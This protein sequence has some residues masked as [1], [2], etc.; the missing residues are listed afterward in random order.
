M[1]FPPLKDK[2]P[3]SYYA[4]KKTFKMIRLGNQSIHAC[5]NDCFLFR[6]EDHKD[7]QIFPVCNTSRWKDSNTPG[8]K[9]PKK[10]LRYF[11]II[12]RL[13]RLYKSSHTTKEMTWHATRK[14]TEPGK[15]QH[16]VDDRAWKN[17]DTK[18]FMLTLLI[19]GPKSPGKDIDVYLRPLIDD[20]KDLWAKP[21]VETID[22]IY[23][24]GFF[25]IM[26]HLV[27]H[28]PLEALKGKPVRPRWM[29]PFERFM[30][31]L[32][33]YVRNKAKL[34]G[35]I[36]EGYVTEE[37]L[38]F[39]SF[40]FHDVTTKCNR[41][42]RNV[43]C[44]PLTCQF[45]VFRS[46]CKS[47]GLRSVIR[48]DHQE[49][50]KVIW[51]V[52]HNSPEIDTYRVKFK[53]QFSN[54]DMK[55]EFPSWFGSQVNLDLLYKDP[56]VSTSSELFALACGPTPTPIS[57]NSCVVNGV[58][59]VVHSRD[60]RR[61]TQNSGICSLG[62]DGEMYYGQ[63]EEIL[64]FSYMSFKTVLF[65][66]FKNDQYILAT[67]VKQCFYLED[68]ARR[69]LDW[70][71]AKHVNHKKFSNGG[72]IVVE[73]DPDIIHVDNSSDLA[74]T[75]SLNDLEIAALHIDGQ[76]IDV[77]APL[78][79]I[80]VDENDDIID[81]EDVLPYD[82]ADSND[83]DLVNVY[84]DD[85]GVAMSDVAR[86]HGDDGG[87]DD[88]PLHISMGTRKPNL[89][90]RKAGMI[91]TRKETRN[92]GLRKI[93]NE[94]GPQSIRFEWKDNGTMLPLGDH[95]SHWA[96]LL[97]EI[98]REFPMHF[99]SWRSILAER[100]AGVLEKIR[101]GHR[102]TSW[103]D[104]HGQQVDVEEGLLRLRTPMTRLTTWKLSDPDVP[105][106]SLW[107]IG[108]S[109]SGFGLI[110]RTWPSV[111]K[112]LETRQRALSYVGRD[113]GYLLPSEIELRDSRVLVPNP[114]LL[115]YTY[116]WWRI[117][118][119][120]GSMSISQKS[121]K[122]LQKQIDMITKAMSSDDR[123]S[124]LFTQL[125]SQHESGSGATKDDESGDDKDAD[126]DEEDADS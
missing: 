34:E 44:P 77:D 125:Q 114:D 19:P 97:G 79:I 72:V 67:Q 55:E 57:V 91:H 46:V 62:E 12:S 28:L 21:G 89:G 122:Q 83:E 47:I 22:L 85:D 18:S 10:V 49:L 80:D 103:Q 41:P 32:K 52:L 94:L 13:Q 71:V 93:T 60:E 54:K 20:L 53:S 25:D 5:V 31:K 39:S 92:L 2:L 124:Q 36:T 98:V 101:E 111:L 29:Y 106:T 3:P 48:I 116:R 69:P 108:M 81:D 50:K 42:T 59:F 17:F 102:S 123:Y 64:E 65:Q 70:K 27:I 86:D 1:Y 99:G 90:G 24:P 56:G 11:S 45:Q 51:Y 104:L 84:N 76:S 15:M 8:K 43:D 113:P 105:R 74:L 126:E 120:R 26:I 38:T 16:P 35:L 73:D 100:K 23:P 37:A 110:L 121:N 107:K 14:C 118:A 58:R 66:S 40:Y 63:L 7:K 6:G 33:N 88:R 78:D 30:K 61:T 75:T 109:R 9:V 112:M 4:I 115:R 96:N 95:S 87:G 68:M 119:G 117:L 82:L